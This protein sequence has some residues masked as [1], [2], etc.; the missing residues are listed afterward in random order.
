MQT[1]SE[2]ASVIAVQPSIDGPFG[3]AGRLGKT[4]LLI[5]AEAFV[6]KATAEVLESAGYGVVVARSAI[7]ALTACR[8]CSQVI[9]LLLSDVEMLGIS[10]ID[11]TAELNVLCPRVQVLLMSGSKDD[12]AVSQLSPHC[13]TY[14]GKPF[15]GPV[16][17]KKVQE[18]L[19]E[20]LVI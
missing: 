5:E 7:E 10:G 4:I 12:L 15:S 20:T 18:A 17:L 1:A 3:K 11:L 8:R 13:K 19:G 9:D 6:R 2:A 16:L 14:L